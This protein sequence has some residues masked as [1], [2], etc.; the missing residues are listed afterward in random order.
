MVSNTLFLAEIGC[1]ATSS[2][3][4][5]NSIVFLSLDTLSVIHILHNKYTQDIHTMVWIPSIRVIATA[6]GAVGKGVEEVHDLQLNKPRALTSPV[7][8]GEDDAEFDDIFDQ[9]STGHAKNRGVK[10]A[11]RLRVEDEQH[12]ITLWNVD[13]MAPLGHLMGFYLPVMSIY[14]HALL[15]ATLPQ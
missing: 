2:P 6:G 8:R 15:L 12:S 10:R 3:S 1:L 11:K 5:D 4:P 7:I 13:T 9:T 14:L